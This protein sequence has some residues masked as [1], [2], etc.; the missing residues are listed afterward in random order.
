M[1]SYTHVLFLQFNLVLLF[2]V[3]STDKTI[4]LWLHDALCL[5]YLRKSHSIKCTNE[6]ATKVWLQFVF[7][8]EILLGCTVEPVFMAIC[9]KDLS[10]Y[11]LRPSPKVTITDRFTVP[12]RRNT[13]ALFAICDRWNS[14]SSYHTHLVTHLK[15]NFYI[16]SELAGM[17][18]RIGSR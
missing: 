3:C 17:Y 5:Q 7:K 2:L 8:K 14:V 13:R 10:M 15:W 4:V 1:H 6:D 18:S 9:K 12:S 11:L 16:N